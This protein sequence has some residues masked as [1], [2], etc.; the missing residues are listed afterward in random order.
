MKGI[1]FNLA[2]EVVQEAYGDEVWERMLDESGVDGAYTSLGNYPDEEFFA[3]VA[4]AAGILGAPSGDVIRSIAQ[5]AMPLLVERY[6]GFFDGHESAHTFVLTLNQIIH[7]EVR[8]LYPGADV[9]E[10][11]FEDGGP[12]GELVIGYRSKRRLCALAE[13]FILGA[14]A[15][16]GESVTINQT[17]CML[18]G[19][20]SCVLR[21]TFTRDLEISP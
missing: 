12:G 14:A 19:A 17:H 18:E 6:P 3:L 11:D 9:P 1:L 13:G 8:K 2:E 5:G 16:F 4:A 10:F 21:C 15:H 7:P 20:A